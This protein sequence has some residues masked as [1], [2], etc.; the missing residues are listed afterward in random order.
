MDSYIRH[1]I[2]IIGSRLLF[3][4]MGSGRPN[5]RVTNFDSDGEDLDVA[6]EAAIEATLGTDTIQAATQSAI[7]AT[8]GTDTIQVATEAAINS[9]LLGSGQIAPATMGFSMVKQFNRPNDT[10]AYASGDWVSSNTTNGSCFDFSISSFPSTTATPNSLRFLIL[11]TTL[12]INQNS[13]PSGMGNF[14][15]W[16][17]NTTT[18]FDDNSAFNISFASQIASVQPNALNIGSPVAYTNYLMTGTA[19]FTLSIGSITNFSI[20]LQ[21]LSGWT[22]SVNTTFALMTSGY[23]LS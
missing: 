7:D 11:Y 17:Y 14:R 19:G 18:T 21:T 23:I 9:K 10:S 22:P 8:L 20:G 4:I 3:I 1:A 12:V 6:M 2:F 16:I 13:V 5:I 15:L